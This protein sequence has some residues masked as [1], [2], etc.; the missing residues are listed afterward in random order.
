MS[1]ENSFLFAECAH[2]VTTRGKMRGRR[3]LLVFAYVLF[4]LVYASVFI[5]IRFPHP[6]AILPLFIWMLV[7]FTWRTV[8]YE[9]CVRTEG[10]KISFLRLYGKKERLLFSFPIAS[11]VSIRAASGESAAHDLRADPTAGGGVLAVI[12]TDKGEERFLFDASDAVLRVIR[13]Y[14]KAAF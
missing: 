13:Y 4:A 2:P 10:G 7:F 14:N 1:E 5:A 8:S 3:V 6:V 12:R 11:I 9:C